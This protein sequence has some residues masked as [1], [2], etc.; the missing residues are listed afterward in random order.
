MHTFAFSVL[1]LMS[2]DVSGQG[3]EQFDLFVQRGLGDDHCVVQCP[4]LVS[5]TS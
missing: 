3:F 1:D 5:G 2:E 4:F